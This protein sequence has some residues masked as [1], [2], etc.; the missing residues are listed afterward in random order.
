LGFAC[1]CSPGQ[2]ANEPDASVDSSARDT[3]ADL[4]SDVRTDAQADA[5]ASEADAD[6]AQAP[7]T[8]CASAVFCEDFES[9]P[10]LRS[11][12]NVDGYTNVSSI[13]VQSTVVHR[14]RYAMQ[15][16]YDDHYGG[17]IAAKE[18]ASFPALQN[19]LFGRYYIYMLPSVPAGHSRMSATLFDNGKRLEINP[20][21]LLYGNDEIFGRI[22]TPVT[23]MGARWTC[24]EWSIVPDANNPGSVNGALYIDG[25]LTYTIAF[26]SVT[27]NAFELFQESSSTND[28]IYNIYYDDV[29][30]DTQRIGCL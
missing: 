20:W 30:L 25:V 9:G 13:Q 1:S 23:P 12:W 8:K 29:A 18:M 2:P 24:V 17:W 27:M 28:I 15:I 7:D 26:P 19:Q 22:E 3:G 10:S 4:G 14:G 16:H 11:L 21:G 5:D 6:A